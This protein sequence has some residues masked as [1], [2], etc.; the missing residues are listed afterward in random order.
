MRIVA[1]AMVCLLEGSILIVYRL[2]FTLSE[3]AFER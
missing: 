3:A 1:R 2:L